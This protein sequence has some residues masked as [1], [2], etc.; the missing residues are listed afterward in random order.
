MDDYPNLGLNCHVDDL[1]L[2]ATA[3]NDQTVTNRLRAG[4]RAMKELV[5]NDLL[6]NIADEKTE[7]IGSSRRLQEKLRYAI[8]L[9][10][11]PTPT[12]A[13]PPA[14]HRTHSTQESTP[15]PHLHPPCAEN[16]EEQRKRDTPTP[17]TTQ[18]TAQPPATRD[19]QTM[20]QPPDAHSTHS[21]HPKATDDDTQ[22][23]TTPHTVSASTSHSRTQVGT[24]AGTNLGVD[25][26]A[27][28]R[29]ATFF[30]T[31]KLKD[32]H[33]KLEERMP[34][35]KRLGGGHR[36]TAR[37]TF[38]QGAIPAI[39]YGTQIWG[40]TGAELASVQTNWLATAMP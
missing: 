21:S 2:G 5:E 14:C 6:C 22:R 35:F 13:P 7:V 32:R 18:P 9:M 10:E 27:G 15:Q 20:D 29:R 39:A 11:M 25:F 26:A 3:D 36:A 19:T 28:R 16:R 37:R 8:G 34:K 17:L 38:R 12:A 24:R 1:A 30:R 31:S 40:I 23:Q 33:H 4:A